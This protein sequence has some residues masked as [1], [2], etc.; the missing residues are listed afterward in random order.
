[1]GESFLV[2]LIATWFPLLLGVAIF[3]SYAVVPV[4]PLLW[5]LGTIQGKGSS[6]GVFLGFIGSFTFF[7]IFFSG[8]IYLFKIPIDYFQFVGAPILALIGLMML[9]PRYSIWIREKSNFNQ[10]LIYSL[11]LGFVW[12]FW[13]GLFTLLPSD[14]FDIKRIDLLVI[15]TTFVSAIIP[16]LFL[17]ALQKS[18]LNYILRGM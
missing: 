16:A 18:F 15:Y 4:I 6:W 7:R 17:I 13:V 11:V 12:S 3:F 1:M 8:I 5:G 2:F 14:N 10:G 9:I